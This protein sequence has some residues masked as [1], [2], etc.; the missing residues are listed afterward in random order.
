MISCELHF[1]LFVTTNWGFIAKKS[2]WVGKLILNF[3]RSFSECKWKW[4]WVAYV[5][6]TWKTNLRDICRLDNLIFDEEKPEVIAVLDWELST[7][8]DP[9]SDLAYSC[10][11]H[12]LPPDFPVLKGNAKM[13]HRLWTSTSRPKG[14]E[15][16]KGEGLYFRVFFKSGILKN[17]EA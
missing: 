6:K 17:R 12:H 9:L 10:L 5:E 15:M 8:G 11:P 7:L 1:D 3:R 13:H 16:L 2:S 14:G 4:K